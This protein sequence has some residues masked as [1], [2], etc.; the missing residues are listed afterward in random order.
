MWG[1]GIGPAL[2]P[3][4]L[5]SPKAIGPISRLGPRSDF[6]GFGLPSQCSSIP[7]GWFRRIEEGLSARYAAETVGCITGDMLGVPGGLRSPRRP[8]ECG[9]VGIKR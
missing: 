1:A 8:V 6:P 4:K 7:R 5:G 3:G 2:M 9:I